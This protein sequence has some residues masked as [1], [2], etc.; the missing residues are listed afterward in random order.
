M[1]ITVQR[2]HGHV[3]FESLQS[4]VAVLDRDRCFDTVNHALATLF[5]QSET[6]GADYYDS[7]DEKKTSGLV[8]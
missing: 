1:V 3:I 2:C 7:P 8:S 6:P 5:D 4:P